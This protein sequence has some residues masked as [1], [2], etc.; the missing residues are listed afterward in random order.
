MDASLDRAFA[1]QVAHAVQAKFAA[2]PKT[3]KPQPHEHTVLAGTP[4]PSPQASCK[5]V[6]APRAEGHCKA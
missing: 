4:I 6:G 2:L 1:A 5:L 3:G